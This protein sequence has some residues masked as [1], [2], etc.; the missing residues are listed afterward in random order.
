MCKKLV[1]LMVLLGLLLCP[2]SHAA[3]IIWVSQAYDTDGDGVQ[4]DLA[5]EDFVRSLGYDLDVQRGNWT[6]LDAA[7]IAALD[8]ADLIIFSRSTNSGDYAND[9]TEVAQW[10]SITTPIINMT[11]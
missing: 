1:L 11:A 9:A 4:D 8:A 7:K 6:A 10:N 3:S 2:A 5:A